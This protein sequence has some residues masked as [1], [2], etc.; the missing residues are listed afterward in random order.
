M[1]G[2]EGVCS[3]MDGEES[4]ACMPVAAGAMKEQW[5]GALQEVI[6]GKRGR[7]SSCTHFDQSLRK[8]TREA[9]ETGRSA[10]RLAISRSH[11]TSLARM[12]PSRVPARTT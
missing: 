5:N 10:A 1:R 8:G 7:F 12:M 6:I 2:E 3:E 9:Y 11:K 4:A